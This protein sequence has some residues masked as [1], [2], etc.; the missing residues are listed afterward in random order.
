[1]FMWIFDDDGWRWPI[2]NKP[3]S[4]L[5]ETLQWGR[6]LILTISISI[7]LGLLFAKLSGL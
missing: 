2:T 5:E 4:F 6:W 1:M 3:G 7:V